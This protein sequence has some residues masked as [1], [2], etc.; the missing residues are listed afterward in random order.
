M[1]LDLFVDTSRKGI[2]MGILS[3]DL[4][5]LETVDA[6]ARGEMA[7]KILDELLLKANATL[8]DVKRVMV[9]VGPGSFS[10]LRTGVAFCEGICFSGKRKLY[11]VSTLQALSTFAQ[12]AAVLI[13]ARNGYWYLRETE[14][15]GCRE[16][17]IATEDVLKILEKEKP[18]A[19]V[20]D[21]YVLQE[22]SFIKFIEDFKVKIINEKGEP[23]CKW[24]ILFDKIPA[25]IIQEANY[26]Q[27]SYFEKLK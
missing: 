2:S 20:L 25:N 6:T 21:D 7:S 26:I 5:Y 4:N 17:F 19:I 14:D 3:E 10:G 12:N 9:T 1:N 18:E 22:E 8:D 11:G 23:L 15:N 27:P 13:R 16:S 24:K